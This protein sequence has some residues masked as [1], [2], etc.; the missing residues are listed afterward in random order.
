MKRL[1]GAMAL[2]GVVPFGLLPAAQAADDEGHYAVRGAGTFSCERYRASVEADDPTELNQ[3]LS[4]VQGHITAANRMREDTYDLF[5]V[6]SPTA[7][8]AMLYNVCANHPDSR[9]EAA[10]VSL[11]EFMAPGRVRAESDIAQVSTGES[12]VAIRRAT[13]ERVQRALIDAGHYQGEP[14]ALF[15]EPMQQALRAF[16]Q[17]RGLTPSGLPDA[18]TIMALFY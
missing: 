7:V 3:F 12:T 15:D 11:G 14:Q 13:L 10:L 5:P 2:A 4:W 16:Q 9:L 6:L 18:D 1:I 8:G 17:A